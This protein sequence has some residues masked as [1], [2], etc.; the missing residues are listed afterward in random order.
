MHP[1]HRLSRR[2]VNGIWFALSERGGRE[3]EGWGHGNAT[4]LMGEHPTLH[5]E[6]N[7]RLAYGKL[8]PCFLW[9]AIDMDASFRKQH[10][11]RGR[12]CL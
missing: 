3:G 7:W 6:Q 9:S 11:F 12:P 10:L 8:V 5:T 4:Q 1:V 2:V